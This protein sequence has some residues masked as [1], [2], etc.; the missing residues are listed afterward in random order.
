MTPWISS[1]I[2]FL[3]LILVAGVA[4]PIIKASCH[5][6]VKEDRPDKPPYLVLED[7]TKVSALFPLLN[8][9]TT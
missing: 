6:R 8:L 4:S 9:P 2:T 1:P 3:D 7:G 5:G